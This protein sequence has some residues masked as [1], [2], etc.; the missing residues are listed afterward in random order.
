MTDYLSRGPY[1]E[2]LKNIIENQNKTKKGLSF[3]IDGEWGCGKT[4]LLNELEKQLSKNKEYLIFHYNAWENDYYDEPLIAILSV[5]IEKLNEVTKQK[6]IYESTVDVLLN[7]VLNDLKLLICGMVQEVTKFDLEKSINHK[8]G[9]FK[10]ITQ[11]TKIVTK[12][13]DN[14]LPLKN[15]ITVV[16]NNIIKLSNKLNII[17]V[18]DELDRCLPEYSIKVLERL[19]HV[20]NEMPVI[21]ILAI[22][23]KD[24]SFGIAKVFGMNTQGYDNEKFADKYLQKFIQLIITLNNGNITEEEN[25]LNG[26]DEGFSDALVIE[27]PQLIEF[28]KN[29]MDGINSR[30]QKQIC[31]QVSLVHKLTVLSGHEMKYYSYGLLCCEL[32]Y[33]IKFIFLKEKSD[34]NI[35][36]IQ[37]NIFK[38]QSSNINDK[39]QI[40]NPQLFYANLDKIFRTEYQVVTDIQISPREQD[41]QLSG[42]MC[43]KCSA[44]LMN[45]F[46]DQYYVA[47]KWPNVYLMDEIFNSERDFLKS[48]K[49]ILKQF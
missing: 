44:Q 29:L 30:T 48:F 28:Y 32:M 5:M 33:C 40:I 46:V 9:I 23:K 39:Y 1:L 8:K 47:T 24:L 18:V 19:H 35:Q 16:R 37:G 26:I 17:L 41:K 31:K 43:D 13:I 10:R 3:A 14:L 42:F 22:N 20:C 25:I 12:D 36:H 49:K 34:F 15:T 4:W 2:L 38:I 7:E 6:S 11:G 45:Y 21:Q 27:K